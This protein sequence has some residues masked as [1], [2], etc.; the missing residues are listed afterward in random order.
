MIDPVTQASDN[1]LNFAI[2]DDTASLLSN[3]DVQ[4][5]NEYQKLDEETRAKFLARDDE[6]GNK[7]RNILEDIQKRT[8]LKQVTDVEKQLPPEDIT[9]GFQSG[10][11]QTFQ[12]MGQT[13]QTGARKLRDITPDFLKPFNLPAYTIDT[14]SKAYSG[15]GNLLDPTGERLRYQDLGIDPFEGLNVGDRTYLGFGATRN[16]TVD[17]VKTTL[18][19][20]RGEEP[21]FLTSLGI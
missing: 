7:L 13:L 3:E 9:Q 17:D 20:T 1:I 14:L 6:V 10:L 12:G 5:I 15:A 8:K 11:A 18:N 21:Y 19:A 16:Y 2:G 4:F